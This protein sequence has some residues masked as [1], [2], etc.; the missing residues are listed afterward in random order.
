MNSILICRRYLTPDFGIPYIFLTSGPYTEYSGHWMNP[1]P[2]E[3][4][5]EKTC[6]ATQRNLQG[7]LPGSGQTQYVT[8]EVSYQIR[9]QIYLYSSKVPPTRS[10][11]TPSYHPIDRCRIRIYSSSSSLAM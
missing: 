5:L 11:K 4:Y 8:R 10:V 1:L 7:A 6:K 3:R 2:G 9:I